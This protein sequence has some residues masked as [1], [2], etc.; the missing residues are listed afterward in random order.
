ML[1]LF[2]LLALSSFVPRPKKNIGPILFQF[3][4]KPV[5]QTQIHLDSFL[6]FFKSSRFGQKFKFP[7]KVSVFSF[8]VPKVLNLKIRTLT[9]TNMN[10]NADMKT[11]D[12]SFE[13]SAG[14]FSKGSGCF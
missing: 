11:M 6:K 5:L 9:P 10:E 1:L 3:G 12:P 4:T 8:T 13:V 14:W 7:P 2:S